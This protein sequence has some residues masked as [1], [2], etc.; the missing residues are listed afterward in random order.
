MLDEI[1]KSITYDDLPNE[2]MQL[3][4]D[5]IGLEA[6][7]KLMEECGGMQITIPR[8]FATKSRKK[9]IYHRKPAH[10]RPQ[11]RRPGRQHGGGRSGAGLCYPGGHA[12]FDHCRHRGLAR[13][14]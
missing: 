10:P 13:N 4:A 5:T 2:D 11:A 12:K 8:N 1:L 9:K 3:I 7:V 14:T 6:T